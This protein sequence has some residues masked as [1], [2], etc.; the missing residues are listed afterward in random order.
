M[1]ADMRSGSRFSVIPRAQPEES[2][3]ARCFFPVEIPRCARDDKSK[4]LPGGQASSSRFSVIPR[5]QPEESPYA[6]CFFPVEIPRCARDDKSKDLPGG[7]ASSSQC[8]E[9][10]RVV[11]VARSRSGTESGRQRLDLFR[12]ECE[13]DRAYILLQPLLLLGS[14]NR[15]DVLAAREQPRERDLRRGVSERRSERLH[16]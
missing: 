8:N 16:H 10:A 11:A 3:Y 5:A 4:D 7:Q 12:I 13:I 15:A 14:R 1:T 2:P 9:I 6:R